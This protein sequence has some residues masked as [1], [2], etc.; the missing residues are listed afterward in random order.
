[1]KILATTSSFAAS[2]PTPRRLLEAAGF[3]VVTNPFKRKLTEAEVLALLAEHKPIGLFAGVEPL[4]DKVLSAAAEHLR[5]V[6]RCGIGLDSV[7]L[8]AAKRLGIAVYS[9]PEAP[10]QAVAELT[11]ALMLAAL[12]QVPQAD[13]ALRAGKWSA[14]QGRLL[15]GRVVGVV[16]FGRIGTKVAEL[17][18]AFGCRVVC[19]DPKPGFAAPSWA[20]AVALDELLA[21]ADIVTLHLPILPETRNLLDARRVGLLK[22][23]VVLVNASRGGLVDEKALE[24]KLRSDPTSA[25]AL[26]VFETEPYKGPLKDLPNAVLTCH[27]GSAAVECRTR[28]EREAAEN[29]IMGLKDA[30]VAA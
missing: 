5:V 23:G 3:E 22:P 1:M 8:A 10:V 19:H 15:G 4:T 16:G 24:A 18:R 27:M 13:A 12:R 11:L 14:I 9:T 30:G 26:D 28:M 6:S 25:A 7:D 21:T 2:D 17:C 29:L 20:Q